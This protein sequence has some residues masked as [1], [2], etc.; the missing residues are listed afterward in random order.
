VPVSSTF[1]DGEE[2]TALGRVR[3]NGSGKTTLLSLIIETSQLTP[4]RS[5]CS[6]N[7]ACGGSIQET[8]AGIGIISRSCRCATVKRHGAEVVLSGF[9]DSV[10]STGKHHG[11]AGAARAGYVLCIQGLRESSITCP[12]RTAHVLLARSMVKRRGFCSGRACQGSMPP[13]ALDP[14][15]R[16]PHCRRGSTTFFT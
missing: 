4:I 6:E 13:T 12:R 2:R 10:V 7:C 5:G 14:A 15:G 16:R 1:L 3:P 9:F 8:K 11:P